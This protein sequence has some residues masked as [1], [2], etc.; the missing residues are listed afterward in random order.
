MLSIAL[1][2]LVYSAHAE[3]CVTT[4]RITDVE[5]ALSDAEAAYA[6]RN[7]DSVHS[8][9]ALALDRLR[10]VGDEV[11]TAAAARIHRAVGLDGVVMK[12]DV[13]AVSAFAAAR[14]LEPSYD[15]TS[16]MAPDNSTLRTDYTNAKAVTVGAPTPLTIPANLR[17]R[18]DGASSTERP[19]GRPAV[20]QGFDNA[21][22]VLISGWYT[23]DAALVL[24]TPV[25]APVIS[26]TETKARPHGPNRP[27]LYSA[28]GAVVAGGALYAGA[29]ATNGA[30][31]NADA[32]AKPGIVTENHVLTI[33][34]FSVAGAGALT[35]VLAVATGSW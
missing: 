2:A 30:Y 24:P 11:N 23:P 9:V 15:Y 25:E 14:I 22:K 7:R 4:Y 10:C 3:D 13:R 16:A 17:V 19:T 12:D 6:A 35:G 8:N 32:D 34:A 31:D 1:V 33:S 21:G 26:S 20:I 18:V 29:W 28:I 27:L 5:Q